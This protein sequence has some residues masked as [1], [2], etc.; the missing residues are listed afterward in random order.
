MAVPPDL[1]GTAG[2]AAASGRLLE[3]AR[4]HRWPVAT[5]AVPAP[6]QQGA[7]SGLPAAVCQCPAERLLQRCPTDLCVD[8]GLGAVAQAA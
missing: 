8:A 1:G 4:W 2:P 3:P 5:G 6:G 7:R